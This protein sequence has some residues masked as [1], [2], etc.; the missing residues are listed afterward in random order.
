[1]NGNIASTN[2]YSDFS[3]FRPEILIP[4]SSWLNG[5]VTTVSF[6]TAAS[7]QVTDY[8]ALAWVELKYPREF[9]FDN[10]NS[11]NFSLTSNSG[12]QYLE[13][14]NFNENGT[15]PILYD[16]SNKLRMEAQVQNDTEKFL[17]PTSNAAER[18]LMLVANDTFAI[19]KVDSL[20][21]V[22]FVDFSLAANQGNF[23]IISHP[24]LFTDSLGNNYVEQYRQW[25]QDN[26][27]Q[28]IL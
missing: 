14:G 19:H 7:T 15:T 12:N 21:P 20:W 6:S 9:D 13:I 28:A 16:F 2:T 4:N 24:F 3:C 10:L 8:N 17:L 27:F 5:A 26:G 11:I 25:K 1:M 18:N 23:I 22:H